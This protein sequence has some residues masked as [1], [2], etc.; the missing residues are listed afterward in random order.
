MRPDPQFPDE[1]PPFDYD[2]EIRTIRP[3]RTRL[4]LIL[5]LIAALI[6][7]WPLWT[8]FYTDWLWFKH[9]GYQTVFSTSLITKVML[10]IIVGLL[11][12]L[13]IWLN[14]RLAMRLSPDTPRIP[15][16]LD[17]EGTRL[18]A[19]DLSQIANR[20]AFL[21]PLGVGIFAGMLAWGSWELFLRFRHQAPFGEADPI[22]GRDISFYFFTLPALE[23]ITRWLLL[24]IVVSLIGSA[25]IYLAR[26][27]ANFNQPRS[28]LSLSTGIRAHILGLFAALFLVFAWRA[29]LAMP[30]LLLGHSGRFAGASYTDI[31]ATLPILYIKVGVALVIAALAIMSIF[32]SSTRLIMLGVGLYLLA[33]VGGWIY[34]AIVQRLSVAPNELA[35]ETPY[36]KNTIAATRKGFGLDKIEER[37]V[38]GEKTLTPR[39]IQQNRT[40]IRNIRLWDREPLLATFAQ[41]QEIRTYYE[42]KSVDNDRYRL[43]GELQQVMLSPRELSSTSLPERNWINER[44]IFT[45]GF[46]LTL[47][48]V[49][50]VTE[51]GLPVLYVKDL[52]PISSVQSL[53]I[54]RPEIYFGELTNDH[55]YVKTATPEF[56]Y[57]AGEENV[58]TKYEGDGG[59]Q[60]GSKWRQTLF[61]T[62]FGDL[63]L[64]FSND[65]RP[66]SRVLLYRNI[67]D[68]LR[69]VAPYLHFDPDPYQ[70]VHDGRLFWIADAYTVS[71]RYPYSEPFGNINYIRNSV[72]AVVDA[73]HGH[74]WLY[75][76]D[77]SDPIIQ[78][79]ARIYPGTLKPLDE[80]P[81]GL[82]AHIRYPEYIF[83]V[84]T[85]VYSTYHMDQ[86]QIFYNK[87]DLWTVASVGGTFGAAGGGSTGQV[88]GDA[89]AAAQV[90]E[91]YY[92]IMKLPSEQTE[93]FMLMLPL[94]PKNKDNLAA[95]MAARSDGENYG[96]LMVF[97]FP[98][99]KLIYGPRQIVA[100]INQD[101]E[102]S[103][104]LTLWDQRGSSVIRGTLMVIPIEESLL[105]V[106]PLYLRADSGRIPELRRVIV[107]PDNRIAMEPTLEASLARIFGATAPPAEEVKPETLAMKPAE[108]PATTQS[109]TNGRGAAAQLKQHFDRAM[110]AQ[111]D[112][113]WARYGEEIKRL[114]TV[115][116]QMSKQQ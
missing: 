2:K 113:D 107:A 22:F 109:P 54:D 106:Q 93:E 71:N 78:T 97:R 17:F 114:G 100:R 46:G 115:I 15:R 116:D 79:Y 35:K 81:E 77:Q 24:I 102:I 45:H 104:Q 28:M 16:Y 32:I 70:V 91:P 87:E 20:L 92:T 9:V 103:R 61:A 14:L 110:Q 56:N 38:T 53:K 83:Q 27:A 105:Y 64:L 3:R 76:T 80:M 68:R 51:E 63:K 34:P 75:I 62:R 13:A 23:A 5:A 52:P 26:G 108:A 44:F 86:P 19:P 65:L 36:I 55:V 37:E 73:Y 18:P 4:W 25:L 67:L 82:K 66:E 10:G 90:M 112:G 85:N 12:G 84:Q 50:Q 48:P 29:Y 74:I 6:F 21:A 99:Q 88:R 59:V 94:T 69:E 41:L 47:G 60:I 43:N 72:K 49:A 30:N 101:P 111:R 11:T 89:G 95:W 1:I 31:H 96:K 39:D 40:T 57:P 8:N 7:I 42:F 98:K 33:L 58:F